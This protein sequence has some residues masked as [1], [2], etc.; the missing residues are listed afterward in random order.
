MFKLR[1]AQRILT[2]RIERIFLI[3]FLR[4]D[5]RLLPKTTNAVFRFTHG[6]GELFL[7]ETVLLVCSHNE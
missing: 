2:A 5:R 7:S 4:F 1:T 6:I 3:E